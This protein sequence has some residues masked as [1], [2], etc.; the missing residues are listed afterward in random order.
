MATP[1]VSDA[2]VGA[3]SQSTRRPAAKPSG[4]RSRASRSRTGRVSRKATLHR[5]HDF[6]RLHVEQAHGAQLALA[7]VQTLTRRVTRHGD[8]RRGPRTVARGAARS[9]NRD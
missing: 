5:L 2:A 1:Y 6:I 8:V 7:L 9:V 3:A 4:T